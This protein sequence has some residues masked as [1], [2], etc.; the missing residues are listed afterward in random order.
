MMEG[1]KRIRN[2]VLEILPQLL[3]GFTDIE[4]DQLYKANQS[5]AQIVGF[6]MVEDVI[7]GI[8]DRLTNI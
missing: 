2:K 7:K 3:K 5:D 1:I 6:K 4:I 8:N